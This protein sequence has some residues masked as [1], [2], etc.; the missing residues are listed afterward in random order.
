MIIPNHSLTHYNTLRLQSQAQWF[1]APATETEALA[2]IQRYAGKLPITVLAGGSNVVLAPHIAGLVLHPQLRGRRLLSVSAEQVEIAVAAGE[3]WDELVAWTV[4]Q[5]WQGLENLSLIP[6]HCGAAP[7]QNIGAYGVELADVL[8]RLS[9]IR[10]ST[11]EK[12]EFLAAECGF[13]YRD[14]YFKSVAPGQWL[15]TELVLRLHTGDAPLKLGYGDVAEQFQQLPLEEQNAQG[16]RQVICAIRSA[17]LPNPEQ[18]PNA[19]SFFK[20]PVVNEAQYVQ[21]KARY[22]SLVA[23]PLADGQ[24]KLAAGWLIE[25]AGWKGHQ[26]DGIGMHSQQALVLVNRHQAAT[27][28]DINAVAEHVRQDVFAQFAVKLEQEPLRLPRGVTVTEV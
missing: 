5:G 3:N 23:Y 21:L 20:N 6:G 15:I 8:V 27:A 12:R 18:I 11:G 13:A 10:L 16:L 4:A 14:S 1:A 22:P 2:L 7:V 28:D 9:A 25:Q 17:K 19:G 26:P 24:Y